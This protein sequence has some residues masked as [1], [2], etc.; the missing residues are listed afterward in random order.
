MLEKDWYKPGGLPENRTM[1]LN[2]HPQVQPM[3]RFDRVS[4]ITA[5]VSLTLIRHLNTLWSWMDRTGEFWCKFP[6]SQLYYTLLLETLTTASALQYPH[7]N[8]RSH[9]TE[10]YCRV[11]KGS[12]LLLNTLVC[13]K[14]LS[15][16]MIDFIAMRF[17]SPNFRI[18]YRT[19]K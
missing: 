8:L 17:F 12:P 14:L 3:D 16:W 10:S 2:P 6:L 1:E 4:Y 13:V 9:Y 11:A 7:F 5:S 15:I 18:C 19:S